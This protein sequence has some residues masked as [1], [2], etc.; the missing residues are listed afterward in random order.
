VQDEIY[1]PNSD[2]TLTAGLRF[3]WFSSDDSPN[4]NEN[5]SNA[6]GFRNDKGIDGLS[7]LMP[8]VGFTWGMKDDLTLRGGIGLFSG[9]N[10]NVWLANAWSRDGIAARFTRGTY[11]DNG[12]RD[13]ITGDYIIDPV[14]GQVVGRGSTSIFDGTLP[15]GSGRTGGAIPTAQFD[16][17]ANSPTTGSTEGVNLIDPNYKQPGEWKLALGG[18]W[19][20]P[21]WG[22]T[23]DIDYMYTTLENGAI[24]KDV[25]QE[26]IGTSAAGAPIYGNHTAGLDDILMLTNTSRSGAAH[27]MSVVM[28]KNF[29][30]GMDLM[31][32]YSWTDAKDMSSMTSFTGSSSYS[33]VATN[34]INDPRA[35]TSNYSQKHRVTMRA[36]FAREFWGDNTT[37]F[38]LMGYYGSGQFGTFTMSSDD[39]LQDEFSS[40]H[41]LYV[42]DGP[43]DPNVTYTANFDVVGFLDWTQ[44]K[45]LKGGS[46][47]GRNSQGT[48]DSS[49]FDLRVDQEIP[50]FV[51]GLKARAYLKIYNFTNM[52][53]DD[54][55]RQHDA[56][57][58]SSSVVTVTGVDAQGRYVYDSF[59]SSGSKSVTQRQDLSSVW[60]MRLGL[61][62]N[63]R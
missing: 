46:F 34:N 30:W 44:S 56:R 9:G 21:W 33:N 58:D 16:Q 43:N 2:F 55:G 61:D 50:L 4:Y 48:K 37:R 28:N 14:T 10:P 25:A 59:R 3:E 40:R 42:P 20:M 52:L 19:D 32:G 1:F 31:L 60:E 17:V 62:I 8:R 49:R 53:N 41:L 35:A 27:V 45:G 57:F 29:D 18:T 12:D 51:D 63:F 22:L 23:A 26:Q 39:V 11:T 54:W 38:T 47:V 36:A 5:V 15:V 13:P 6:L 7:L 24:Y